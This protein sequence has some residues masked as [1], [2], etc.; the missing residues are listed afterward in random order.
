[1]TKGVDRVVDRLQV[2]LKPSEMALNETVPV[3]T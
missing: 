3:N 2:A 1:M